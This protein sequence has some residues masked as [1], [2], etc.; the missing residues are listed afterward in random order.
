[1]IRNFACAVSIAMSTS[2]FAAP[3]LKN[4]AAEPSEELGTMPEKEY[5]TAYYSL[6]VDAVPKTP[7]AQYTLNTRVNEYHWLKYEGAYA[8]ALRIR[9]IDVA[10]IEKEIAVGLVDTNKNKAALSF[11]PA[12]EKK[13]DVRTIVVD[14]LNL[15]ADDFTGLVF[16]VRAKVKNAVMITFHLW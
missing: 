7:V 1:M 6:P 14:R 15:R 5:V 13:T 11:S 12:A 9:P 4:K 2:L 8:L 3:A 16:K 10:V